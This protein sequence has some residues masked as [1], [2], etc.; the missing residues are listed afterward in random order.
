MS[1][2]RLARLLALREEQA[3]AEKI[4]WA[5]AERAA[6]DAAGARDAGRQR[7]LGARQ[8]LAQSHERSEGVPGHGVHATLAAYQALDAL[9]ARTARD[10]AALAQARAHAL[11]ARQP[12]DLRR[13]D[14]E[15]LKRLEHR[16]L[17]E[18][19]R[20]RRK[21]ENRER[22]AFINGRRPTESPETTAPLERSPENA[23]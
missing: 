3:K 14:V 12:Y 19:R 22:E 16:W 11:E 6:R 10:D 8:E 21:K 9:T 2:F 13:R 17:N 7:V 18:E 23:Q 1:S 20:R 5:Q 15:A 4:H